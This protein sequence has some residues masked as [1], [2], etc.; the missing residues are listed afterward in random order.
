MLTSDEQEAVAAAIRDAE[1]GTAGEVVVVLARQASGYHSVPVVWGL[2]AA[3]LVPWPLIALTELGATRIHLIQLAAAVA[4][5]ASLAWPGP[6]LAL[7]PGFVKRQRAREAAQREF[8]S[9]GLTRTRGRTGVLIYVAAAEHYA[10]VV[11]DA[12][13]AERVDPAVWRETIT[14]LVEAI[15]AGA[16]AAGL[17]AA[18]GR[19]GAVLAAH[20]PPHADDVDELPNKVFLV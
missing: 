18:V 8:V 2:L 9:R 6:R 19:V 7:V 16:P 12:G 10:E 4:L 1:A 20:A 14:A 3:L 5:V 13:V 15:R 17:V 11:A